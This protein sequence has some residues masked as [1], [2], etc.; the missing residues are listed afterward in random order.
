MKKELELGYDFVSRYW[1][2]RGDLEPR[3]A[4]ISRIAEVLTDAGIEVY[5]VS[6]DP[7]GRLTCEPRPVGV[8]EALTGEL[9][10]PPKSD[11][12][13]HADYAPENPGAV[14]VALA[15]RNG[16]ACSFRIEGATLVLQLVIDREGRFSDLRKSLHQ[17]VGEWFQSLEDAL[18]DPAQ[19]KKKADEGPP[20]AVG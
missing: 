13:A 4:D 10:I 20:A 6:E 3:P 5:E 7:K 14:L 17:A 2:K 16:Y 8:R 12:D 11:T 19:R 15:R 1:W 9:I 18:K